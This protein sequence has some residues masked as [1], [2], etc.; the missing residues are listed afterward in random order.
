ML[1]VIDLFA[2][3]GGLTEGFLSD[4]FE[5]VAHVEWDRHATH[6]LKQRLNQV[7]PNH[8]DG[9]VMRFDIQRTEEMIFGFED[10]EEFGS[11]PG[12]DHLVNKQPIDVV[13][14][15]P[16]CQAYSIAGRI[17]DENGMQDDYRNYLFESF[18]KVLECYKPKAFI[19]ENVV[20]MLSAA[21]GGTPIV[22]R[23]RKAFDGA[24]Y[25]TISDYN[26]AVFDMSEYGVPQRRRRVII[27][28]LR[29]DSFDD[30]EVMLKTFHS[31]DEDDCMIPKH[32]MV[33]IRDAIGDLPKLFPLKKHIRIKGRKISHQGVT[34][35]VTQH[36]SRFHNSRDIE[37]FRMLTEDLLDGTN[38]YNSIDAIK[39]LYTERTGKSANVHKYHVIRPEQPGNTIPAHLYKDGLRHIHWDPAQCRTITVREAACIQGFPRDFEYPV[40]MGAAYKMIGNAVPPTFAKLLAEGLFQLLS[41]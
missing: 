2:G 1:R 28:G 13:I 17:R 20:G 14:G 15:G 22:E 36:E 16:P 27:V 12:L 25:R 3:C 4:R 31:R 34:N 32:H 21:P 6:V 39:S 38:L 10:D 29:E 9:S 40:A 5:I 24:G 23:I 7:K 26:Q 8:H 30:V 18:V 33:T 35:G 11:H 41:E 19:F 37:T